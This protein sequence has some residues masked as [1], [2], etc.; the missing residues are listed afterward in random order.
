[1]KNGLF[2]DCKFDVFSEIKLQRKHYPIADLV[3]H[4]YGTV[5][6]VQGKHLVPVN[7][8]LIP[9]DVADGLSTHRCI[10]HSGC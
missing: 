5:F 6:E 7:E 8:P 2:L 10:K 4:R 3:G 9:V 1:M